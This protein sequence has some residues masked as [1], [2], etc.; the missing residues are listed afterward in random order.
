MGLGDAV[1][2]SRL[3]GLEELRDVLA[4]ELV[5]GDGK[6]QVAAVAKQLREVLA[7][8]DELKAKAGKKGSLVDE[9]AGRREARGS[10]AARVVAARRGGA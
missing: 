9:L 1:K 2:E 10:G 7:E 3:A 5:G 4:Q 6:Q 8:I